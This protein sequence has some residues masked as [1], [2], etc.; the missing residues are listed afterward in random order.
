M[1]YH[2]ADLFFQSFCQYIYISIYLWPKIR[3]KTA[4]RFWFSFLVFYIY[5]YIYIYLIW[6]DPGIWQ[7]VSFVSFSGRWS[8]CCMDYFIWV[9][10]MERMY[11]TACSAHAL[12]HIC[13]PP[14]SGVWPPPTIL[15]QSQDCTRTLQVPPAGSGHWG[16]RRSLLPSGCDFLVRSQ[17]PGSQPTNA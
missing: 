6:S 3:D 9:V 8:P 14:A 16:T 2:R 4:A 7:I 11:I 12:T 15:H 1:R 17:A 13:V 5:I 10:F